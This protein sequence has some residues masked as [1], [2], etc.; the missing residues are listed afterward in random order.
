MENIYNAIQNVYNMDKTTWQEVL[1]ELY[2]LVSNVEN[3]FDL[4]ETKFGQ[5]LDEEVTIKLKKMYD[6]GSLAALINDKP[7]IPY[8]F[9]KN[10]SFLNEL[11]NWGIMNEV[12]HELVTE[13]VKYGK[14][15]H[16][17]SSS[18][19]RKYK[20]ITQDIELKANTNYDFSCYYLVKDKSK[21][22]NNFAL[23]IKGRQAN[24]SPD[25]VIIAKKQVNKATV[26][27]YTWEKIS[28]FIDSTN[29]NFNDY[30]MFYIYFYLIDLGDIY[31]TDFTLTKSN[32]N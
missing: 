10:G 11:T 24:G 23:E 6:D 26:N 9:I 32:R 25:D 20:G 13:G 17:T 16:L 29:V 18:S 3:K 28:I 2:N 5:L 22:N 7:Y 21:F 15:C 1:A 31:V 30:S 4:F 27:E 12:T 8:N 19:E 14:S